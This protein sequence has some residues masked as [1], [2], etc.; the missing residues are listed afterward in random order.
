[1]I[2]TTY[3]FRKHCGDCRLTF[4]F[5]NHYSFYTMLFRSDATATD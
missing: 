2:T 1:M 3:D 5:Y 4:T